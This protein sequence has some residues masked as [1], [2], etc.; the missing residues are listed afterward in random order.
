M[1]AVCDTCQCETIMLQCYSV[2][3]YMGEINGKKGVPRKL[4]KSDT[5]RVLVM[6]WVMLFLVCKFQ[7]A[8]FKVARV[9]AYICYVFVIIFPYNTV[10]RALKCVNIHDFCVN[11]STEFKE[12][13][14]SETA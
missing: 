6:C 7:W 8:A 5:T 10:H 11:K 13:L 9:N 12:R 14:Y 2:R 3:A 4:N 1:A